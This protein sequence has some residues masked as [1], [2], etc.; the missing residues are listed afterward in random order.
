[1]PLLQKGD[2]MKAIGKNFIIAFLMILAIYQTAELWFEDFSSHNFFSF[3]D[4][5]SS[6]E[7]GTE[8]SHTLER[9]IIN[10]GEN[11]MLC[12]GNGIYD[13]SF[14]E[15]SDELVTR[16][17]RRGKV[18]SSGLANWKQILQNRCFVYEYRC[19]LTGED[20]EAIF[21]IENSNTQEIKSYDTVVLAVDGDNVRLRFINSQSLWCLEIFDDESRVADSLT[22]LLNRFSNVNND[23]YYISSVQNGFEIFKGN[24]F[25]PR[26]DGQ[27]VSYTPLT[28]HKQYADEDKTDLESEVNLF[29]NNPAGKWSTTTDDIINFSDET[30]VVKYYPEGVLEYSNYSSGSQS[31]V[32]DFYTNYI[33]AQA[34]LD[35]DQGIENEFYLRDYTFE[36]NEYVMC[37]G[38]KV[39]DFPVF[40]SDELKKLSGMSDYIE[41]TSSYGRVSHYK[42]YCVEYEQETEKSLS[43]SV[44]FLSAVDDVYNEFKDDEEPMVDSL[45]LAYVDTGGES[46][47]LWWLMDIDGSVYVRQSGGEGS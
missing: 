44:D 22:E 29:F 21:G 15:S 19:N 18:V 16:V 35:M 23:I 20:A 2:L 12:R 47:S 26:W 14:K 13:T 25:I 32:N 30:T 4:K 40:M 38:Y 5:T 31:N 41:I 7:A 33:A 42:R 8:V 17:I 43:A 24:I 28:P 39:N 10:L 1:M 45:S 9:V 37:F 46:S 3:T 6:V 27:S 11:K 34:V 36:G